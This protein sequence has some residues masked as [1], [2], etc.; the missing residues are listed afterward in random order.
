MRK[1][2]EDKPGDSEKYKKRDSVTF[3]RDLCL[4]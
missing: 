1:V 4:F 3:W 2:E